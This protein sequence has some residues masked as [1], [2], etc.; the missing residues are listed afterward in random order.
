VAEGV[1]VIAVKPDNVPLPLSEAICGL[2][3]ALSTTVSVPVRVPSA[4]GVKLTMIVQPLS[5]GRVC[6]AVGQLLVC[7]KSPV[8]VMD[9]TASGTPC[10][11]LKAMFCPALV[12]LTI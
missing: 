1:T 12:V 8:I 11:F 9:E 4:V 7:A 3:E 6:G 5:F 2:F 10:R